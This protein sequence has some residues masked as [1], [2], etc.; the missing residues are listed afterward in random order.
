M[1]LLARTPAT[2]WRQDFW[3]TCHLQKMLRTA[4]NKMI[5]GSVCRK[6]FPGP[7]AKGLIGTGHATCL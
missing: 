7:E 4:F 3:L 5:H 1:R 2:E 6:E